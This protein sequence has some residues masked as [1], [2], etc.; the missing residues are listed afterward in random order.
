MFEWVSDSCAFSWDSSF[1]WFALSNFNVIVSVIFTF[2]FVMF[3]CYLLETC[4]FLLRDRR[5]VDQEV[6]GGREQLREVEERE[7]VIRI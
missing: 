4:S 2:Y 7:T 5:G 1:C 3:C 6:R